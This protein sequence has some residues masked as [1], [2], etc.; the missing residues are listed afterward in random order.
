MR[1]Y[2]ADLVYPAALTDEVMRDRQI[3]F[4]AYLDLKITKPIQ[5]QSYSPLH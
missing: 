1:E 5:G 2:A 4:P 3:N